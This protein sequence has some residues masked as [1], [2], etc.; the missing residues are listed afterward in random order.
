MLDQIEQLTEKLSAN[1][2]LRWTEQLTTSQSNSQPL[3]RIGS[4]SCGSVWVDSSLYPNIDDYNTDSAA[5]LPVPPALKL[6]DGPSSKK[7][8]INKEAI[9]Y[10]HIM[11]RI[12]DTRPWVDQV[13]GD[14][15]RVNIPR[16]VKCLNDGPDDR[17][18]WDKIIPRIPHMSK[19]SR[20]LISERILPLSLPVRRMLVIKAEVAR[21]K[22][23]AKQRL[24]DDK[25]NEPFLVRPYLGQKIQNTPKGFWG[26]P[27]N[28]FLYIDLMEE[29]GLDGKEYARAM[30][31]GLAFMLW[32]CETNAAGV[33]FVIARPRPVANTGKDLSV[34]TKTFTAS[35]KEGILGE[36]EMWILDF[37]CCKRIF[38]TP[39]GVEEAV[40]NFWGKDPYYPNP[41]TA[42]KD[43]RDAVLW[44]VFKERF[45]ETSE[46]VMRLK[47]DSK[48]GKEQESP[49]EPLP[50]ESQQARK[51]LMSL[52]ELFIKRVE[53]T[54]ED[55]S[56]GISM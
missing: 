28:V 50:E 54:A 32:V 8:Q 7:L 22:A 43:E 25:G 18:L 53:E 48:F 1:H 34:G 26:S 6:W 3:D 19:P 55:S 44:K 9:M 38:M 10:R 13:F 37:D 15:F 12:R 23:T 21:N 49:Q 4:G 24:V 30:A 42:K 33:D 47:C 39:E 51:V 20:A 2:P 52:P 31:D 5:Y 16:Y 56:G 41:K 35:G 17:K 45:L 40:E 27:G 11:S 29:L 14:S 46:K 36:H